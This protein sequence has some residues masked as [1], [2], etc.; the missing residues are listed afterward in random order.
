MTILDVQNLQVVFT[1]DQGNSS[2]S[3]TIAVDKISFSLQK[4]EIMG[5][6]GESGSGKSVTSLAIMGL[7]P[8]TG[9]ITHG[10]IMFQEEKNSLPIN[11]VTLTSQQKRDYR[12][13]KIA[14]IFQEPMSSLNPVYNIGFQIIEAIRLHQ[15]ISE[16][17]AKRKAIGLLQEVKLLPEDKDLT[18]EFL[19]QNQHK[20]PTDKDIAIYLN[21][22]KRSILKRFPHEMSGG[23]LQ[24]V[25]IAMAISCQPSILI[26]DEPTTALDVTVQA[27]IL[28]LLKELCRRRQMSLI[29][30]THDLGVVANIADSLA[31]MYQGKIVEYGN[32][33]DILL[34]PQQAYT[35][36]LL[37]C[38]PRLDETRSYLP[39][40]ADFMGNNQETP[41]VF[42]SNVREIKLNQPLL[43]VEK[44]KVGFVKTG[45]LPWQRDYFWAV[46]DVS[47]QLFAG[48]TLGLVG[49][50]G[51]GKSTLA[52]T[53]LRLIPSYSGRIE[54][55]NQDLTALPPRS[56]R[57][58]LL[59]KELQIVFQNPYNSLNPRISIGST[60]EEPM[61]IHGMGGNRSKRRERVKYLLDRVGLNPQWFDRYPHEL[62]GGQR[63]RVCIARALALNPQLIICDESVSALDV[64]IQAQVLNLLKELQQEFGLTYIFIS[65]DLSV[66]KFMSD[67]IMVM[68][69]G[70]IEE[71]STAK[72]IIEN[73]QREYTRKLI[74][75]I[76]Q[77]PTV[78][79]S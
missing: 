66:V 31:V 76:P 28:A 27:T 5:I 58:R 67:R 17:E 79:C 19:Q 49:E 29:F 45:G 41:P 77:F 61:V 12:G 48:E 7:L 53:I 57:L 37:A 64:S 30:I 9:E 59:R 62:S 18:E 69:R 23:Q 8:S 44:L 72:Q 2:I 22:K 13:G 55:L 46:N 6:V 34:K 68:N 38:R 63:Q 51:C 74:A 54:F 1:D 15:N 50:S 10:K 11:L 16:K 65:H 21:E 71:I 47:F 20:N 14:M 43:R 52:R 3:Y 24:R 35:Q 4:G 36:G 56:Q 75:S 70:K 60:I 32:I 39:T 73:P 25:M 26:A 78:L 33:R 42:A 40:V